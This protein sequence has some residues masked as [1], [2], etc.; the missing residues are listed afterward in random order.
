MPTPE[1]ARAIVPD[2]VI[3]PPVSP[4]PVAILVT[5]PLA[6]D[7]IETAPVDPERT[8]P[9]PAMSEVTPVLLRVTLPVEEETPMPVPAMTLET[10]PPPPLEVRVPVA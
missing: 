2:V 1:V 6:F 5:V 10:P 7:E 8:M 9:A 3:G 4:A